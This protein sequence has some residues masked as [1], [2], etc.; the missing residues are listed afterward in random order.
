MVLVIV[1]L[2]SRPASNAV[3]TAALLLVP[4]NDVLV[5]SRPR[6]SGRAQAQGCMATFS[7]FRLPSKRARLPATDVPGKRFRST[8]RGCGRL[9]QRHHDE[10]ASEV[11]VIRRSKSLLDRAP[12]PEA[13]LG[14][15][16][17]IKAPSK[18][19]SSGGSLAKPP[20]LPKNEMPGA[21]AHRNPPRGTAQER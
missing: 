4:P 12:L 21:S 10:L 8:K 7:P 19:W 18:E 2:P 17:E 13:Q 1:T 11:T 15:A 14:F 5:Q 6:L 9:P 3:H 16:R 20:C